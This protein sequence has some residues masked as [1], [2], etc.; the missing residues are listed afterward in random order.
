MATIDSDIADADSRLAIKFYKK[1]IPMPFQS[2][3]E[4]R[5]I[6]QD[7]DFIDI[8]VPGDN[9]SVIS[10]FVTEEHK[11]RFPKAWANYL[12]RI[13]E[14]DSFSGTPLEEWAQLSKSQCEELKGLKF[15]TVE[16]IANASDLQLQRVGMVGG[17]SQNAFREKAKKFLEQ[18]NDSAVLAKREAE[19]AA[20]NAKIAELE[21]KVNALLED[22]VAQVE[23]D[24][25]A[26]SRSV[27]PAVKKVNLDSPA[28]TS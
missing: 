27:R 3:L 20:S 19:L 17:M 8:I 5:P 6:F 21:A 26:P 16:A 22:K 10:T 23:D 18:A 4:G 13:T 11:Q 9:L 25:L 24:K 7:A 1:A 15:M 2:E 14:D 12:N 28:L